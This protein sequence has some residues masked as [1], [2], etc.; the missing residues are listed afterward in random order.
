MLIM[1]QT[2]EKAYV[3]IYTKTKH[4]HCL[5]GTQGISH[6]NAFFQGK[7]KNLRSRSGKVVNIISDTWE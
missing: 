6:S 1:W 5:T 2:E 3:C 4:K 7:N